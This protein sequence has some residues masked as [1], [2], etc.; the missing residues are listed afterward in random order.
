VGIGDAETVGRPLLESYRSPDTVAVEFARVEAYWRERLTRYTCQT[1]SELVNS[2]VNTWN[3][4]QCHTTFNWSRSAS[5]NE[6]GG[7]DGLGYRDTNQDTLGVVHAIPAQVRAK[8][9]DLLKGQ[10]AQGY[11]AHGIQPLEWQQK[12]ENRQELR[13]IYSDDHL[14]LLLAVPAYLRET[15]DL[16]FL[17]EFLPYLDTG[18]ASVYEHL[19]QALEFSWGKRGPHGLLLGLRADWN[20]CLNLKG[21]GESLWSTFLY[22][23]ALTEFITL[24]EKMGRQEEVDHYNAYRTEIKGQIDR[25]AWDGAWFLRGYLDSG[26]KLGGQESEQAKIFINSQTWAVVSGA[27][28]REQGLTAMD[29]LHRYLATEHGIVKNYPAYRVTDNEIGAITSFPP[30]LKENAGIFCHANTWA[31]VAECMLGRGDRAFEYYRSFLPAAKND[32]AELYT[33]EPYVYSQFITGKEHPY[34]FGRAR[35]SWLTGTASWSFVAVSQYILGIRPDFDGLVV[36]PCIPP[37]WDG[38]TVNRTFRGK[39]FTIVVKNPNH[40]SSGVAE[41]RIN[42]EWVEGSL[43]P[44]TIT[45]QENLVEVVLGTKG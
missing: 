29:S 19:K 27:A 33:M 35:N 3:Q 20:D 23:L 38:F 14:W 13:D 26:R 32:C 6:A 17:N 43:I 40:Q 10:L 2:M 11:A 36:D 22:Y 34:H 37:E 25:F 31:I 8:L 4:Y 7:R 15:G 21:K 16:D 44:L 45:K 12:T 42:G 30:G 9:A 24:A 39:Q 1:P 5:F 41:L 28:P 18:A